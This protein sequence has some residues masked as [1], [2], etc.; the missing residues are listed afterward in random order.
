[1]SIRTERRQVGLS[2]AKLA[3]TASVSRYRLH[4]HESGA[5]ELSPEEITRIR[6]ALGREANRLLSVIERVSS[7]PAA[8]I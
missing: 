3:R 4:L 2:Q 5:S 6:A 1:M 8:E 7:A